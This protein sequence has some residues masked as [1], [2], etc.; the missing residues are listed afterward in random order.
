VVL[1]LSDGV[2]EAAP[3]AGAAFGIRRA[4]EVV[5]RHRAESAQNIAA[6]LCQAA[7]EFA[8]QGNQLD[9]LTAIV[10]KCAPACVEATSPGPDQSAFMLS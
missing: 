7:E 6:A 8:G 3:P 5:C 9:D 2:L 10:I 4:A 1:V